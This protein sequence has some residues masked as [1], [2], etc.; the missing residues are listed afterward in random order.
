MEEAALEL[1]RCKK[2]NRN[3]RADRVDIHQRVCIGQASKKKL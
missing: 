2:C 3:F 1:V